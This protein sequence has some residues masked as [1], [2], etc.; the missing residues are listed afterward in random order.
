[1]RLLAALFAAMALATAAA[2]TPAFADASAGKQNAP[3]PPGDPSRG[4]EIVTGKGQC[5]ACHRVHGAGSRVGP[6]LTDVGTGRG[7]E[8]LQAS[9][10]DPDAEILPENRGYRVVTRDGTT[11]TGRILNHDTFQVLMMDAKEQLRSF[12]KSDLREHAFVKASAM[13]SYRGKLTVQE[14]ADVVA[15]LST[16]K[17]VAPQ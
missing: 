4:A 16:L 8:Q 6:D 7:P 2:R 15:Y 11:I 12:N 1:M 14:L 10:V 3:L 13:P 5:L 9:L 17:G